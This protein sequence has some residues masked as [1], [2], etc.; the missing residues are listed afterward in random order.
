M[1]SYFRLCV[2]LVTALLIAIV[3]VGGAFFPTRE[4]PTAKIQNQA[5]AEATS[6]AM[7][8]APSPLQKSLPVPARREADKRLLFSSIAAAPQGVE[9]NILEAA[10]DADITEANSEVS[11]ENGPLVFSS[12]NNLR[13]RA[14]KGLV[15]QETTQQSPGS[16]DVQKVTERKPIE[17]KL[18]KA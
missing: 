17:S 15:S 2:L 12:A 6:R 16:V 3:L 13:T 18:R 5:P 4:Q 14:Q 1:K 7:G 11:K 8:T 10:H 9:S